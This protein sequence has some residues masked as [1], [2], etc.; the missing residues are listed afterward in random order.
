MASPRAAAA[1]AGRCGG[2]TERR[3]GPRCRLC[4]CKKT[5]RTQGGVSEFA[6]VWA[7]EVCYYIPL[8]LRSNCTGCPECD[9]VGDR[10]GSRS[11]AARKAQ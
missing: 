11:D 5:Q 9:L 6:K 4:Q 2:E 10:G 1:A 7:V 3:E 8:K